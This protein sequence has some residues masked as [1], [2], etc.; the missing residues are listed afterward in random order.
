MVATDVVAAAWVGADH[1]YTH[2]CGLSGS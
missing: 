1:N 2:S